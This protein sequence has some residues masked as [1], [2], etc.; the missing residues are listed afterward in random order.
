MD[1]GEIVEIWVDGFRDIVAEKGYTLRGVMALM[2]SYMLN[3]DYLQKRLR[4]GSVPVNVFKA[5]CKVIDVDFK[6]YVIEYDL[7]G[8]PSYQMEDELKRRAEK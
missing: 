2:K 5:A 7:S 8:V 1:L 3:E 4:K 6:D